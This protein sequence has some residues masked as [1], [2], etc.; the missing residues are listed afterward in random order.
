[1]KKT[2][3]LIMILSI[4][5]KTIGFSRD[6]LLSYF[7]GV[8]YISDAYL[9]SVTIPTVIVAFIGTGI[10]TSF[11]PMYS[12]IL[13]DR[14]IKSANLFTNNVIN[15]VLI[16]CTLITIVVFIFT[17]PI[18]RLFA[19]GFEGEQFNLTVTF[20]KIGVFS[21]YFAGLIYIFTGYLQVKNKFT[22]SALMGIPNNLIIMLSIVLSVNFSINILAFGTVIAMGFQMLFL[23]LF[24]Y[25]S[26]FRYN[27]KIGKDEHIMKMVALSMPVIL[28]VSVNQINILIDRTMASHVAVGGISALN[29]ADRINV[30]VQGIFVLSI[31]TVM[32]P[33]ISKMASENNING[34]KNSVSGAINTIN[35]LVIP[36]S[37][38][39]MAL[40][41]PLVKLLFGRGVFDAQAVSMTSDVL[42]F[43]SL[44]MVG[45]GLR[46]VLSRAF[47]AL[48]DTKTP[49]INAAI[50]VVLNI[51]LNILLAPI[52]G[53]KGL[54]L[55]TSISAIFCTILLFMSLRRK[56]GS[57]GINKMLISFI[58]ILVSSLVMGL[59]VKISYKFLSSYI[60][61]SLSLFTSVIIGVI[62]YII[63]I[64]RMRIED[65]YIIENAIKM[66]FKNKKNDDMVK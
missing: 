39:S 12:T 55:S 52:L 59:L 60:H 41:E 4:I 20:T 26:G 8:S 48:Q 56:I 66:R 47:Y 53:I 1:M 51:I 23:M 36:V 57:L 11:V 22:I 2:V 28:G 13:K 45:F 18:V 61:E 44:G 35:L 37:I 58:K 50:A 7:Y 38:G 9:I 21:V 54:A 6:I 62:V 40:A 65:V 64:Y 3:L 32:Y 27:L 46:E 24:V 14:D 33:K 63:V 5:T 42:F 29:Y 10:A 49:A 30:F 43:Y 19:S 17:E 16:I 25:K 34:L 31:I 15:F